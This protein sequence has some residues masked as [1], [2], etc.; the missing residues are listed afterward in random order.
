MIGDPPVSMPD[1]SGIYSVTVVSA[2]EIKIGAKVG[3]TGV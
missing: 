1:I 3:V 2:Y